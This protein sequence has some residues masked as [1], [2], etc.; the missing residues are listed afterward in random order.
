MKS[1]IRS[2]LLLILCIAALQL[3]AQVPV[4][5]SYPSA[6]PVIFLDFDGHTVSGTSW[7]TSGPIYCGA[8]GLNSTQITEV[9][10]R[11]AEDY[12]PFTV[13]ITTDST[14]YL[15]AP[16]NKR[17]RV[18]I[19]VTSNWYGSAG[20]TAFMGSFTW[21]DNTPC[22]VFSALL[23]YN[24]KNIA[25]AS[26]HEAGHTLGL[27]HQSTYDANCVK[28]AEYNG[29]QG[30]GE[31]GWAPIMGVGYYKNMTLWH[32][33]PNNISCNNIQSDLSIITAAAN[34]ISFR[35]DDYS[36]TFPTA[37]NA[38]FTNNQ[39]TINGVIEQNTD[40]D[41]F[42]F[43]IPSLARFR[44]D[45]IPYNVGTGNAGSNLD[46]Q[47]S[48]Y[49]SSQT[50]LGVYNP[51]TLLSSI[52]DTNLNAGTYYLR[53]EGKDNMYAP[54]YG[55]LGSY[56]MQGQLM[57]STLP[58]HKLVL[59]GTFTQTRHLLNWIVEA[60]EVLVEQVLEVSNDGKNFRPLIQPSTA[61]RSYTY[62]PSTANTLLYRLSVRFDN[63][64]HYYSNVV[65]I[66]QPK[67]NSRPKLVS[68]L[69]NASIS[70]T[71]PGNFNCLL[72]DLNGKVVYSG[73][74][75]N[76]MNSI[77]TSNMASGMYVIRFSDGEQQWTEKLVKQ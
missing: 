43:T 55:S 67:D 26:S 44:L 58:L 32:N 1:L 8:S 53:V 5:S 46:L 36:N 21:G 42:K 34:G 30:S 77:Q 41:L 52:I 29:G 63:N 20:G 60:D 54:D 24:V 11:V 71:S 75:V 73:K 49:N 18:I 2:K 13:N 25:E 64:S 56:A 28:T 72:T 6:A 70:I 38:P 16:V 39:F 65:T 10:N 27:R 14:K 7:N 50:L 9:F 59:N 45:A 40:Q 68:N 17:M 66:R 62:T 3:K 48:L 47:V 15:A 57:Q 31:I 76:G 51:G 12:R 37:T 61:E 74:L 19:T 23:N 35:T 22:F 33:G 69:I 4:Y